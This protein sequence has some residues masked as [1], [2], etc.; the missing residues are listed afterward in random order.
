MKELKRPLGSEAK[1]L[2]VVLNST[3]DSSLDMN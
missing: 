3:V 1:H 2:P